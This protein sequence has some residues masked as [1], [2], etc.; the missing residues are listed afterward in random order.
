MPQFYNIPAKIMLAGDNVSPNN[1]FSLAT[2]FPHYSLSLKYQKSI[3]HTYKTISSE[4]HNSWSVILWAI[5]QKAYQVL[6]R[7]EFDITG[8]FTLTSSI[9]VL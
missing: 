6:G 4:G 2:S 7:N 3:C 1:G 8:E 5:I 9:P